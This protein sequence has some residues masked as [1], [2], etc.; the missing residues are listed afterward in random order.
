MTA[1]KQIHLL[2]RGIARQQAGERKRPIHD[3]GD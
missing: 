1:W 3:A 2:L